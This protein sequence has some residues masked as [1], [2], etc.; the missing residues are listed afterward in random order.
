MKKKVSVLCVVLALTVSSASYA[1]ECCPC[2]D[3]AL[4]CSENGGS[5][6]TCSAVFERCLEVLY[7]Q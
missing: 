6:G 1:V 7:P 4:A 3:I 2:A 5:S